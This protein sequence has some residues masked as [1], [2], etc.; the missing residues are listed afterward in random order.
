MVVVEQ[1]VL[2]RLELV[3]KLMSNCWSLWLRLCLRLTNCL[4]SRLSCLM[5][6]LTCGAPPMLREVNRHHR[7]PMGP[8]RKG[9]DVEH[10]SFLEHVCPWTLRVVSHLGHRCR[11][12][13]TVRRGSPLGRQRLKL[14]AH[15]VVP[16]GDP[17]ALDALLRGQVQ[18][19]PHEGLV[20]GHGSEEVSEQLGPML[21]ARQA[22]LC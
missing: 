20:E 8:P 12:P 15:V 11:R 21:V 4:S 6:R 3:G 7:V 17:H 9:H 16:R 14:K 1:L 5:M 2:D 18:V 13:L 10:H 22:H 19:V